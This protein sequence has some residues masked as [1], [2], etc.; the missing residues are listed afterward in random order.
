MQIANS[1]AMSVMY[2]KT[3]LVS[4]WQGYLSK[5]C[6][7][8]W[9]RWIK[10][11]VACV[12]ALN[13]VQ[14][15]FLLTLPY[16]VHHEHVLDWTCDIPRLLAARTGRD[17]YLMY[18]CIVS[19]RCFTLVQAYSVLTFDSNQAWIRE[20]NKHYQE[21]KCLTV[22]GLMRQPSRL[23]T[24]FQVSLTLFQ[25][26]CWLVSLG[27][28]V[29]RMNGQNWHCTIQVPLDVGLFANLLSMQLLLVIQM[30]RI[31]VHFSIIIDELPRKWW[32]SRKSKT[33]VLESIIGE[34]CH[35]RLVM[36]C[37][38]R[39]FMFNFVL[40]VLC[41]MSTLMGI[42]HM[43]VH[44]HMDWLLQASFVLNFAAGLVVVVMLTYITQRVVTNADHFNDQLYCRCV[45]H[46]GPLHHLKTVSPEL[47]MVITA[48]TAST[49]SL[50]TIKLTKNA[51]LMETHHVGLTIF[52]KMIDLKLVI[53]VG[54]CVE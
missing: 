51:H 16:D 31:A 53:T 9:R 32:Q 41:V 39:F 7:Y 46:R 20:A 50:C 45:I 26:N 22:V 23:A 3:D 4:I 19:Y 48:W 33:G 24:V 28:A 43:L 29:A 30:N 13:L 25:I 47:M 5:H 8:R 6:F 44:S 17:R 2:S 35:H 38:N 18:L 54:V 11:P 15:C 52:G 12:L 14:T 34:Y 42:F 27:L 21:S 40:T 36:N 49:L 1:N 37:F 10:W